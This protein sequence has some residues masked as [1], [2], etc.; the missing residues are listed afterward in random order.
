MKKIVKI[1]AIV[2][3]MLFVLT[4]LNYAAI[5]QVLDIKAEVDSSKIENK[6]VLVN[7]SLTTFADDFDTSQPL[8]LS[9]NLVYSSD[10]FESVTIQGK[11]GWSAS[12]SNN[13][14]LLDAATVNEDDII[15]TLTFKIKDGVDEETTTITLNEI[16]ITDG[17]E[18]D[19]S[20]L[21][22]TLEN[23][24]L[25]KTPVTPDTNNTDDEEP[26]G[27]N[28]NTNNNSN[29]NEDED[30]NDNNNS[31]NNDNNNNNNQNQDNDNE[32][33]NNNNNSSNNQNTNQDDEEENGNGNGNGSN[34]DN[35]D[36]E[37]NNNGNNNRPSA[38]DEMDFD[39][40]YEGT[41]TTTDDNSG[42]NSNN[43]NKTNSNE[44]IDNVGDLTIANGKTIPQTGDLPIGTI[45]I[46]LL[47]VFGVFAFIRYK[48]IEIKAK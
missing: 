15:A 44:K 11:N 25:K 3:I 40:S 37:Q 2:I 39:L 42:T 38:V 32:E 12:L 7:L 16:N 21:A 8:A 41:T 26:T 35:E 36:E 17:D 30:N 22:L 34:L 31:N 29:D 1:F 20:D 23:V 5:R 28:N 10:I 6:K 27:N 46:I 9:G 4:T 47:F 19:Y 14:F 33:N 13:K 48:S 45:V 18:I 24:K 43:G